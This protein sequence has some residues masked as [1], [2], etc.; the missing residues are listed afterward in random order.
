MDGFHLPFSRE[1]AYQSEIRLQASNSCYAN[2]PLNG[3]LLDGVQGCLYNPTSQGWRLPFLPS[4]LP[5]IPPKNAI[6]AFVFFLSCC[7]VSSHAFADRSIELFL[8]L[9]HTSP[10]RSVACSPDGTR[11]ASGGGDQT[12]K[13]W[14]VRSGELVRT[15]NGH[16]SSVASVA[17]TPDG[18]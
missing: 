16:S 15:L 13:L 8:Q 4:G 1:Q 11:L 14:D 3:E 7:A 18:R 5:M 6:V 2:A 10:V 17:F 9:G 12:V